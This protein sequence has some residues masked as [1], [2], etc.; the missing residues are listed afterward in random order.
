MAHTKSA[1][2]RQRQSEKRRFRNR[3]LRKGLRAEIKNFLKLLKT[4]TL[5]E[6]RKVFNLCIQRLDKVGRRRIYH[7]NKVARRKSQ[8]ARLLNKKQAAPAAPSET[9]S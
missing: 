2:K 1:E 5:E 8:L 4:G 9:D 6:T 7:P 3:D